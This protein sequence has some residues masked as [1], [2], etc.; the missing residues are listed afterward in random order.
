[1]PQVTF[2]VHEVG[3]VGLALELRPAV[4]AALLDQVELVE[5]VLSELRRPEPPVGVE[6]QPLDV[7]VPVGPDLVVERVAGCRLA[8]LVEAQDRAVQAVA[9]LCV[10]GHG[11]VAD[12]EE[13][14]A[15]VVEHQPT[16]MVVGG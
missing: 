16:A 14:V 13:Q 7:A 10:V 9:V 1:M 6:R 3:I 2:G 11:A 4:V 8:V 5:R 12:G 15:A